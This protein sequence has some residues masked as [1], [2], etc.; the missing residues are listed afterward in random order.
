MLNPI[1][2]NTPQS[3]KP[4]FTAEDFREGD[5]PFAYLWSLRKDPLAQQQAVEETKAAAAA[6]GVKSFS[7]LWKAY[8][9]S[10]KQKARRAR[11]QAALLSRTEFTDQP[12]A[13]LCG[14]YTCTDEGVT[15]MD[16]RGQE[17]VVCSHPILPVRRL[18]STEGGE[19]KL[20]LAWR[21]E[22]QGWRRR[23]FPKSQLS[24]AT[25]IVALSSSDIAVTSENARP[26]VKYIADLDSMNYADIPTERSA[27]RLGWVSPTAFG[28]AGD[29]EK[30]PQKPVF[31]PY[32]EGVRFDGEETFGR[33]HAA[34]RPCGDPDAWL[35]LCRSVRSGESVAA[36]VILA[37]SFASALV[38]P[39]R[40][41]PFFVHLWGG[42]GA[43]K[44]VA[45]K[46]AASV[47]ADPESGN[48]VSTYNATSASMEL[49]AGF[50]HS[51]PL[52]IDELQIDARRDLD[53][54]VY[55]L[56]EG[57]GKG[58]GSKTGGV[59]KTPTW[60]L[61]ILSTGEMPI[62]AQA[63]RGGVL[64]RC[65]EIDCKDA[66]L[67]RSAPAVANTVARTY[68]HGGQLFVDALR[69]MGEE[70][71][72]ALYNG[73]VK[74]LNR[75]PATGKQIMAAAVLL[76]A[77]RIADACVF[78]DGR[79]LTVEEITPYLVTEEE[80][81]VNRRALH[82]ISDWIA[83]NPMRFRI[84]SWGEWTGECWGLIER[85]YVCVISSVLHAKL[86][87]AGYS[88]TAFLSW[89]KRESVIIPAADGKS[90][91]AHRI[92]GQVCRCVRIKRGA[93]GITEDYE[94]GS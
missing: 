41:L 2:T 79:A 14:G 46:L 42:S 25:G 44:T 51:L 45:L 11:I 10:Q 74:E 66:P 83:S 17:V 64:N 78:E 15:A 8:Q 40:A 77:D 76:T 16:G 38:E 80:A 92:A 72:S 30:P 13:L 85:D 47:W 90:T 23:V 22:G 39:C 61:C 33:I 32:D 57:V 56:A 55:R 65:I 88:P 24:S 19:V 59:Q 89:A 6:L 4:T 52:C 5:K 18:I 69:D 53:E 49:T 91:T 75:T 58:R 28:G 82:W 3:E 34:V 29:G 60:R 31:I 27:D 81:D 62:T 93:V 7:N 67:F 71:V 68:G 26:L 70:T 20:E 84:N 1:N 87:E 36:R 12:M 73:Y 37:A 94:T 35:G 86:N 48:F 50:L 63:S 9:T 21:R 43:G 54:T